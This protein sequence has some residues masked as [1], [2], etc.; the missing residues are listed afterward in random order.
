[1]QVVTDLKQL[2][3][4]PAYPV[5]AIGVFDGVHRGHQQ[6]LQTVVARARESSGTAA[7]LSF[8]PHPQKVI[9]SGQAPLL[10]QTF[11]QKAAMFESL[12]IDVFVQYPFSR[13]LSLLSPEDF[14]LQVIHSNGI[15]EI[16]VGGNFRFGHMRQGDFDTLSE[17]GTRFGFRVFKTE[18]VYFRKERISSTRIR[19]ALRKGQVALAKRLLGRP[20]ELT[21]NVVRGA[22]RGAGLGF[23]TANLATNNE[24]IPANGVY[25]TRVHL[26]GSSYVGAT[27]IGHRPTVHGYSEPLPTVETHLLDYSGNLYGQ[28]LRL[29]FCFRLRDEKRFSSLEV[30]K[31]QIK[32]DVHRLRRYARKAL[33]HE[34]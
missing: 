22:Q 14:V 24:L 17:L 11:A 4:T 33:E 9:A 5:M 12:G 31:Q 16:H 2:A 34:E 20:Y 1:M 29:E 15:R 25:A 3:G 6:I 28:A 18:S 27:N 21:G 30:L 19:T 7:V 32:M 23:A 10:L 8:R 26:N 13:E